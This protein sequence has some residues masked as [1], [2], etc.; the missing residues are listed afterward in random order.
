M[1]I[2]ILC[3]LVVVIMNLYGHRLAKRYDDEHDSWGGE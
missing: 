3:F 1:K 2:L